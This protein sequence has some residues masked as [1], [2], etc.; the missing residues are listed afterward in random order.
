MQIFE[1]YFNPKLNEDRFFDSFVYEP[2]NIYEK[3][4]GSLHIVGELKNALPQNSKLLDNLTSAI[5]GKYYTISFNLPERAVSEGLKKAN[6]FL[7]EE[8][9][10]E[11]VSWLGNLNYSLV[12]IKNSDL[13][14]TKTG[15]IKIL[16]IRGGQIMDIGK[17]L[18]LQEIDPYPLKI[19][20]NI[21]SGKLVLND[22]ILILTKDIYAF[23]LQQNILKNIAQSESLNEKKIK[24][25]M[26]QSLFSK[27]EG[28]KIS[29]ICLL[30][31]LDQ[32]TS[33][34][35]KPKEIFFR[36]E[37]KLLFPKFFSNIKKS[38][39]I[40]NRLFIFIKNPAKAL[41]KS[42]KIKKIHP[43][44]NPPQKRK[45]RGLTIFPTLEKIIENP[46]SKRK[47]ILILILLF[48][49]LLGFLIFK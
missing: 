3:K 40:I 25:I 16:L 12:S 31:V 35:K 15:D 28:V 20:F 43:K 44:K 45:I 1:L 6:E 47:L 48:F 11:N 22:I 41:K 39:K 17:N 23:F 32:K 5:K 24:E 30:V 8:V 9:K 34:E 14:F 49:L 42:K 2:E 4:L 19:F 10:K 38:I 27:R 21:V 26:P 13:I 33:I 7:A 37:N 36:E 29:G 18:D 46:E